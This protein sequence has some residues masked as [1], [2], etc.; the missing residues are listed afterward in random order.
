[1]QSQTADAK[2][3]AYRAFMRQAAR[4]A[5]LGMNM[6]AF[7]AVHAPVRTWP[8][9]LIYTWAHRAAIAVNSFEKER[10]AKPWAIK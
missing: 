1:M 3:E 2:A 8:A 10:E 7:L 6:D 5:M 9:A 4:A